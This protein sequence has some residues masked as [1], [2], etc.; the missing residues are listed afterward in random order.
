MPSCPMVLLTASD[1][2]EQLHVSR[3]WLYRAAREGRIPSVRLGGDDGPVRFVQADLTLGLRMRVVGGSPASRARKRSGGERPTPGRR[4][5]NGC[6]PAPD[7][8]SGRSGGGLGHGR[9]RARPR[10]ARQD[11]ARH[12]SGRVGR[13]CHRRP[14]G[15]RGDPQGSACAPLRRRVA[16]VA[17]TVH[18]LEARVAG[19]PHHQRRAAGD[20]AATSRRSGDYR[21][22]DDRRVPGLW[23]RSGWARQGASRSLP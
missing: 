17:G 13:R 7:T 23:P 1:V 5:R 22:L 3:P 6:L 14:G 11:G 16:G 2:C 21:S 19:F 12:V 8:P 4:E 20:A 10:R 15:C 18:L 9:V